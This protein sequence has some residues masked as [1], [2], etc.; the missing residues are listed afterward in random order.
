MGVEGGCYR[1]NTD[2]GGFELIG[3]QA[4]QI[5]QRQNVGNTYSINYVTCPEMASICQVG[6]I[7]CVQEFQLLQGG[8][9]ACQAN[10]QE[11]GANCC[12][13][14][15]QCCAGVPIPRGEEYCIGVN[16]P[17]GCPMG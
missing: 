14:D 4:G 11:C 9:D 17:G 1:L 5:T 6:Q 8:G 10:E 12:K 16:D 2:Q 3:P 13:A 7:V 15:E